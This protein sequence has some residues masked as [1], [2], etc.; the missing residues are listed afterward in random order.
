MYIYNIHTFICIHLDQYIR[1]YICIHIR[2][3]KFYEALDALT[4]DAP[5]CIHIIQ[6]YICMYIHILTCMCVY[7]HVY[8]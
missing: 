3:P 6:I 2:L 4:A 7:M 1:I 8:I 5:I